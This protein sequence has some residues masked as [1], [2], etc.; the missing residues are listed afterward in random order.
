MKADLFSEILLVA[1]GMAMAVAVAVV[2]F[3]TVL[4]WVLQA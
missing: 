2:V 4:S 3:A 1:T